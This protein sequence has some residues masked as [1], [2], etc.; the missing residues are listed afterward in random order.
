M[1]VPKKKVSVSRRKMRLNST[2][3]KIKMQNY[4]KCNKCSEFVPLHRLC[5]CEIKL[6]STN[7][8]NK[9]NSNLLW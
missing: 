8:I 1:A 3:Y 2:R 4:T 6:Y 5:N 7:I 9:Y